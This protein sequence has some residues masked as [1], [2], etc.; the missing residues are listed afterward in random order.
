MLLKELYIFF[1]ISL[2]IIMSSK[3]CYYYQTFI[4]LQPLLDNPELVDIIM[5][6]S[7][8]FGMNK[9]GFPYIYLN[10]NPPDDECFNALWEETKI[11]SEKGVKIMLMMG[12]AGGA[13]GELFSNYSLYYPML[14]ETIEKYDWITGIDLDIEENVDLSKVKSLM[15]NIK[16]DFGDDFTITMAPVQGALMEDGPGL[17]GFSYKELY[18]S[19]EGKY[20]SHFNVQ[21]YNSYTLEAI[22]TIIKNGYPPDKII[23]GMLGGSYSPSDWG[24]VLKEVK[25]VKSAYTD[26]GGVF[27]W[28]YCNSP[29][30]IKDPSKWAKAMT[31]ILKPNYIKYLFLLGRYFVRSF[32]GKRSR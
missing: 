16:K 30:D 15:N 25:N 1:Y 14:I 13:Y 4:G 8:H 6:S 3:I 24:T 29:P 7:I 31:E 23:M 32:I 26:I 12:G 5:V 20:I 21:C 22:E 17:G 9:G 11:L 27:C 2:I 28:E 19:P 10:D 18:N